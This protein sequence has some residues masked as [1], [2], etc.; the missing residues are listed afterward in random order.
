M[1]CFN[2]HWYVFTDH[3]MI[4]KIIKWTKLQIFVSH[5][6]NHSKGYETTNYSKS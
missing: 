6:K 2:T 4:K 5:K 1:V 3:A